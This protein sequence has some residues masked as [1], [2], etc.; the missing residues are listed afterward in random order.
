MRGT[1]R[2]ISRARVMSLNLESVWH[3]RKTME[4]R[5]SLCGRL[6]SFSYGH[7]PRYISKCASDWNTASVV[8]ASSLCGHCSVLFATVVCE[9]AWWQRCINFKAPPEDKIP[10]SSVIW[11]IP[12][13][14]R[15]S[16]VPR[17]R[18]VFLAILSSLEV[19]RKIG[20][21]SVSKTTRTPW[22]RLGL[23]NFTVTFQD[24]TTLWSQVVPLRSR[25]RSWTPVERSEKPAALQNRRRELRSM[26]LVYFTQSIDGKN[27]E[28]FN[29]AL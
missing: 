6:E 29:G 14:Q 5:C 28:G 23:S 16:I 2:R 15:A 1:Y 9:G 12:S 27:L 19:R 11:E 4:L 8:A 3:L 25:T 20:L 7:T 22:N 13:P 24:E 21:G 17:K 18:W 26:E 10:N